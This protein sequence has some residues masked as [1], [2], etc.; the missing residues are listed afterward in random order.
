MTS[1]VNT[2]LRRRLEEAE[3]T[4]RAIREGEID[5][6]V[7]RRAQSDEVFTLEGGDSYRSF[8]EAMTL[9]AAAL[10]ASLKLLYANKA[11][12]EILDCS[13]EQLHSGGLFAALD[14]QSGRI[15]AALA[16]AAVAGQC[17]AEI[18]VVGEGRDRHLL[19]SAAPLRLGL[20]SGVA[21]TFTDLTERVR[22]TA[23]EAA[24]KAS[25]AVIAS[26]NEAMVVCDG[27]GT[28]THANPAA[29]EI[30]DQA[31]VGRGFEEAFPLMFADGIAF[32]SAADLLALAAEGQSVRGVEA[33][34]KDAPKV[35]DVLISA[36][37]LVMGGESSKG[38]VVTLIDLSERKAAERQQQLLM[39]ELDHRV[40]NTL[41]LVLSISTLTGY[42]AK[43]VE[44]FQRAFVGRIEALAATHTLL[45]GKAWS[46][47]SIED[48]VI[49]ELAPYVSRDAGRLDISGL[50]VTVA[51]QAAVALGLVFHELVTNAVKYGALSVQEGRIRIEGRPSAG[52]RTL[53]IVWT[54]SGG[55]PVLP[56]TRLGFGRTVITK[57]LAYSDGG[58]DIRFE[59][60]GVV[61]S[62]RV[63]NVELGTADPTP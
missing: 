1:D 45:A 27:A 54:E 9:G 31:L 35:K 20:T 53:E 25:R 49:A 41:A 5:A 58:A 40:R 30:R 32:R 42:N 10:D 23:A 13:S 33:A 11:L 56:P 18:H 47:L 46:G 17:T 7:I 52:G 55:P 51:P 62:I 2:D 50:K 48:V 16:E 4:L 15:L 14:A 6:L 28:I 37:P 19:A 26:A 59:P 44:D 22:A 39:G 12:C 24:E 8:M 63:P 61:C 34:L 57:S 21:I 36:A 29:E 38:V 43:T 3:E 60:S